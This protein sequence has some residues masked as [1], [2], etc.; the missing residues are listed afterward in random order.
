MKIIIVNSDHSQTRSLT[1]GGW[2]RAFLSVCLLGIPTVVGAWG[3]NWLVNFDKN[4][5][6]NADAPNWGIS[7]TEQKEKLE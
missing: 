7:L 6:L 2:T 5:S 3:Y 4:D 1:L